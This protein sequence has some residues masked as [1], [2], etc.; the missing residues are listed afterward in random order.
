[1]EADKISQSGVIISEAILNALEHSQAEIEEI[2]VDIS[3]NPLEE[4]SLE[5]K[6]Y[7]QGFDMNSLPTLPEPET[8]EKLRKRGWGLTIMQQLSDHF[9]IHSNE[10]GT[11]VKMII[12]L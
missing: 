6:D 7:G 12:K 11:A 5:V 4:I 1:M 10:S 9:E 3:I 2:K 8:M